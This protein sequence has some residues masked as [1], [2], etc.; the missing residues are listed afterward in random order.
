M[1]R[2][3]NATPLTSRLCTGLENTSCI[4]QPPLTALLMNIFIRPSKPP[5][6]LFLSSTGQPSIKSMIVDASW[7]GVGDG[8]AVD[9]SL[10]DMRGGGGVVA[11]VVDAV[12]GGAVDASLVD[13]G[14]GEDV[15]ASVDVGDTG[16]VCDSFVCV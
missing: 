2:A 13:V 6:Q 3:A 9:V 16:V 12:D 15:D 5:G 11:S 4:V 7:V 14:D 1:R 8:G 10:V